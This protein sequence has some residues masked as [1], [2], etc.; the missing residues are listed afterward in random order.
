MNRTLAF[1]LYRAGFVDRL[2]NHVHDAT[3]RAVADRNGDRLA[4]IGDI[5]TAHQTFGRVHRNRADGGFTEVLRDFEHEALALVLRLQ[6]VQDFRQMPVELYV[7]DGA[8][9]LRDFSGC[10]RCHCSSSY[11]NLRALPRRR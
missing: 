11:L 1:G 3:E 2:A 6:R 8:D 5:L 10:V 9:D 4:G 7:D